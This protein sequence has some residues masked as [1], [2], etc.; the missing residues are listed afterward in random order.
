MYTREQYDA[1]SLNY[2]LT[3]NT[4]TVADQEAMRLKLNAI[5]SELKRNELVKT[6]LAGEQVDTTTFLS[7]LRQYGIDYLKDSAWVQGDVEAVGANGYTAVKMG[8]RKENRLAT[9]CRELT[10]ALSK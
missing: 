1:L 10:A 5:F 8:K 6:W 2:R 3:R 4:M 9:L 7:M